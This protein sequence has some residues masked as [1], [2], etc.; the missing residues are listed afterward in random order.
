V[1][2]ALHLGRNSASFP[3]PD[4][5]GNGRAVATPP[6]CRT[7]RRVDRHG[8]LE[9]RPHTPPPSRVGPWPRA[10]TIPRKPRNG[11]E[12]AAFARSRQ[13]RRLSRRNVDASRFS[14]ERLRVRVPPDVPESP[15]TPIVPDG[16]RRSRCGADLS[17]PPRDHLRLTPVHQASRPAAMD[18]FLREPGVA[19]P[20]VRARD[21]SISR[22]REMNPKRMPKSRA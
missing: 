9:R 18:R 16:Q 6:I 15:E 13:P 17:S 7:D 10:M 5:P 12:R 1:Q 21:E 19:A 4:L 20:R 22:P 14:D 11:R 2:S 3:V 8:E